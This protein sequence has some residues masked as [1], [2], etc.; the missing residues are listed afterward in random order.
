MATIVTSIIGTGGDY[1]TPQ[2]WEDACSSNIVT[3]DQIW[4]GK[5]KKQEFGA[6]LI[7][8]ITT[9]ATHYIELITDTGAS[10]VDDANLQTNAL[11]YNA[12]NGAGLLTNNNYFAPVRVDT[13]IYV[14]FSKIQ[15]K[16]IGL[17]N[18]YTSLSVAPVTFD[19]CI[20]ESAGGTVCQ[21]SGPGSWIANSLIVGNRSSAGTVFVRL[22]G[23]GS[24]L[25]NCTLVAVNSAYANA[26]DGNYGTPIVKNCAVFN[27]TAI[28][29]SGNTPTYTSCVTDVAS[30]PSGFTGSVAFSTSSGAYFESITAGSHDLRIKV[31]SALIDT[32]STESTYAATSINGISRPSGSAYDV[33]CWEY[34][35]SVLA[36]ISLRRAF[37]LP[38]LN[39]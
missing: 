9:D 14:R 12:S 7:S 3:A 26:F 20:F 2:A 38:I 29:S 10:F 8:G 5:L 33:G 18:A 30:P 19:S 24:D 23:S 13:G 16:Q 11:R 27:C 4:Q 6:L 15:I 36:S 31:G 21:L 35:A 28:K 39:F 32:G 37:P 17:G 25:Y 1:T 22:T 34:V